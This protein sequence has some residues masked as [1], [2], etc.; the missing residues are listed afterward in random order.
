MMDGLEILMII[1]YFGSLVMRHGVVDMSLITL[2]HLALGHT[3][4][5]DCSRMCI[6]REW[7]QMNAQLLIYFSFCLF[8]CLSAD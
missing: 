8:I 1:F 3:V 5:L 7:T 6:G 2:P 4:W